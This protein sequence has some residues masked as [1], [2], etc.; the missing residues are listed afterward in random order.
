MRTIRPLDLPVSLG[1]PRGRGV[2][3]LALL[4]AA[5]FGGAQ[6]SWTQAGGA[7]RPTATAAV[8]AHPLASTHKSASTHQPVPASKR[9]AGGKAAVKLQVKA[10]VKTQATAAQAAPAPVPVTPPAPELPKWPANEKAVQAT[11]T[12]DSQG[13][14]IE[15][16]N[17]SLEQILNDV[18]AATGAKVEGLSADQRIFGAYGPGPAREVLSRLLQGSG[19][20]VMMIGD[21]GQG[22]PRKIVL[23]SPHA[24]SGSPA[25]GSAPA[26]DND[27]DDDADSEEQ[28]ATP[29][30]R[31]GFAPGGQPRSPQQI[32][33]EMQQSQ[34]KQRQSQG[35]PP[36]NSQN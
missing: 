30:A 35:Q 25:V 34:Q 26:N 11:V 4:L 23:T 14:R 6:T 10:Q 5:A 32:M 22:T 7:Q 36:E 16:A 13:L 18:A 21:Q 1:L 33:Q 17:S 31:P 20:N 28:P 2:F 3:P 9:R 19:Y 27:N 24:G 15:A 29:P 8:A 12:W